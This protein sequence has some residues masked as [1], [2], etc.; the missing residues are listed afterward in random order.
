M[1]LAIDVKGCE[2]MLQHNLSAGQEQSRQVVCFGRLSLLVAIF[3]FMS[4]VAASAGQ[5][6]V[7]IFF[8]TLSLPYADEAT[9][10][11]FEVDLARAVFARHGITVQAIY[12]PKDRAADRLAMGKADGMVPVRADSAEGMLFESL[13]Y[14][15]YQNVYLHHAHSPCKVRKLEDIFEAHL[16]AFHL[17]GKYLGRDFARLSSGAPSYEELVDQSAQVRRF[18]IRK[19]CSIIIDQNIYEHLIASLKLEGEAHDVCMHSFFHNPQRT[20][21]FVSNELRQLFNEGLR[22][23]M[24]DGTYLRLVNTYGIVPA[25]AVMVE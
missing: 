18:L 17:A 5:R 25:S 12:M 16:V 21:V 9:N 4:P 3:L 23:I 7:T 8:T 15:S 19:D 11:G 1:V 24:R 22:E 10:A 20:F 14:A 2:H 13:P 6:A